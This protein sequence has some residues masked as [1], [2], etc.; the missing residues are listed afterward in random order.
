MDLQLHLDVIWVLFFGSV[1][2]IALLLS[3]Y[4]KFLIALFSNN[5]TPF[6]FS[7]ETWGPSSVE[8]VKG[9]RWQISGITLF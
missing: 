9:R 5:H 8:I 7:P 4:L 1:P 6:F 2:K 3:V